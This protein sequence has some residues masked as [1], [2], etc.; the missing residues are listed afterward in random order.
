MLRRSITRVAKAP[1]GARVYCA[2][3]KDRVVS[4]AE[5][6]LHVGVTAGGLAG[7]VSA[8]TGVGGGLIL[9]PVRLSSSSCVTTQARPPLP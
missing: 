9:I 4:S 3:P 2:A 1:A 5:I 6:P 8:L 7:V